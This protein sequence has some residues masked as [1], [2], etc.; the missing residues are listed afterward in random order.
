MNLQRVGHRFVLV[1][2]ARSAHPARMWARHGS[3]TR[4][5][6]PFV[7]GADAAVWDGVP[8][9]ATAPVVIHADRAGDPVEH[10]PVREV[11]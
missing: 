5:R 9:V 1:H 11:A 6:E 3:S 8:N 2:G 7:S 4:V 10:E